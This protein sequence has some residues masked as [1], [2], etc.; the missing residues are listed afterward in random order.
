VLGEGAR[1]TVS[2]QSDVSTHIL[3]FEGYPQLC[4][5]KMAWSVVQV[6]INDCDHCCPERQVGRLTRRSSAR[7]LSH[8][9]SI[10]KLRLMSARRLS[11]K[12]AVCR[13]PRQLPTP[14][15]RKRF[16]VTRVGLAS[17]PLS[18]WHWHALK[19]MDFRW[20]S[21]IPACADDTEEF[22]P[23]LRVSKLGLS[24]RFRHLGLFPGSA[25]ICLVEVGDD[26]LLHLHHWPAWRDRPFLRSG[27]LR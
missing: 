7:W 3:F 17:A 18:I 15:N 9:W 12:E 2:R 22:D 1:R 14:S 16:N 19:A 11:G 20:C 4:L 26:D 8:N 5:R 13:H 25:G 24:G 23:A 10:P 6:G 21:S 27:S